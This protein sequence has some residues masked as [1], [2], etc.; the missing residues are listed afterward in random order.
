MSDFE[1]DITFDGINGIKCESFVRFIRRRVLNN[2][3]QRDDQLIAETAAACFDGP[4]LRWYE[5]LDSDTQES[6]K[7]LR[8]ALLT[9]WDDSAGSGSVPFSVPAAHI[10]ASAP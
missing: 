7:L 3:T 10:P 1:D 4:A 8:R 5:D 2:G 9:R 6:W